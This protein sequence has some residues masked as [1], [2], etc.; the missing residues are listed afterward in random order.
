MIIAINMGKRIIDGILPQQ[1]KE[2]DE[3]QA[4]IYEKL[5]PREIK[6]IRKD[7]RGVI[8]DKTPV[9]EEEVHTTPVTYSLPTEQ[10]QEEVPVTPEDFEVQ[11]DVEPIAHDED[12]DEIF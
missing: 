4:A 7:D 8:V 2:I 6:I 5:L 1:H 3:N 11:H 9:E 12:E 10:P